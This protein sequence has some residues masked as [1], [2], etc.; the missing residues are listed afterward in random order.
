M[1]NALLLFF[2]ISLVGCSTEP[3][4]PNYAKEV[5]P[6][7]SFGKKENRVPVTIVRDK[8]FIGGGCAITTFIDGKPVAELNT[9]E[10]VTAYVNPGEVIVGAGFMGKVIC[11]GAPKKEREFIVREN[12]PRFL[13]VFIDQSGNVDILPMTLN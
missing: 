3:V 13:R 8:G 2:V 1:K 4:N 7:A 6:K 11:S 12:T 9:S 5:S 10:K